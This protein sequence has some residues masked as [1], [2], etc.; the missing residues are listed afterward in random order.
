MKTHPNT[1]AL[2]RR[3]RLDLRANQGK[4]QKRPQGH[5]TQGGLTQKNYQDPPAQP[6]VAAQERGAI[7]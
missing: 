7:D 6:R 3:L 1:G 2:H 4:G 5:G